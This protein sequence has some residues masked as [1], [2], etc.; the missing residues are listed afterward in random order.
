MTLYKISLSCVT[1]YTHDQRNRDNHNANNKL[2]EKRPVLNGFE[3][4][5]NKEFSIYLS[6]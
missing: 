5:N 6:M 1:E 4:K 3:T 2:I